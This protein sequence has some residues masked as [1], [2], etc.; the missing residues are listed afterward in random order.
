MGQQ[1][2][3]TKDE[4]AYLQENWGSVSVPSLSK[5]LNRSD[6]AVVQKAHK[7]GLGAVLSSGDYI[8]FNQLIQAATGSLCSY[9]YK[10]TSWVEKRG[11]PLHLKRVRG[12][13][14]RVVYI[15]EFWKW[16]EHNKSFI[17][18]SKME[19]LVLGEEPV[20][21]AAQRKKDFHAAQRQRKNPW[22][23]GE[24]DK[25]MS[26]LRQHKYGYAELSEIL[27]RS[28][29]AIQRRINDLSLKERPVKASFGTPWRSEDCC[30]L[31]DGIKAGDCYSS[32]APLIGKSEKAIRGKIY[33]VY[34]TENADAIRKMMGSGGWG[35][36]A[37]QPTVRQA[38][39]LSQHKTTA[40][41]IIAQL[42][43]LLAHRRNELGYEPFW[44]RHMCAKWH[45][46]KGCTA[47][48]T[49]CDTCIEFERI[50]PQYCVRCGCTFFE[51]ETNKVCKPCREARKKQYQRK[52][53]V[54]NR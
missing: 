52:W 45:S 22:S 15:S 3:W 49:D 29:G 11:L 5:R 48:C 8:T 9:S 28:A 12:C 20:W 43:G 47:G 53:A 18:F 41:N 13:R 36:G 6:G 44:Q 19:P 31:A 54:L 39:V 7:L 51:R 24:D 21:V 10:M 30:I 4:C 40:K 17:D 50:R 34:L 35:D 16:A 33:T 14:F 25:L 1:R 42:A 2:N 38:M 32:I 26:L 37:P 23:K 46:V 27:Q